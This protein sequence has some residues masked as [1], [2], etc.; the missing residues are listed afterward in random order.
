MPRERRRKRWHPLKQTLRELAGVLGLTLEEPA[1][2][3]SDADAEKIEGLIQK[4]QE[5][6]A[7]RKFAEADKVRDELTALGVVL[8]DSA[9]GT[10]W[11]KKT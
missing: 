10:T 9:Q 3:V 11:K 2:M 8:E 4:R 1:N 6:R 7:A 5:L